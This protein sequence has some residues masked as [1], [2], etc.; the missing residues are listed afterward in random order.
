M[1]HIKTFENFLKE[2]IK[3]GVITC[4]NCGWD[5]EIVPGGEE[6]Y[7]C[8]KCDHDNSP[9][10]EKFGD[11]HPKNKYIE[12]NAKDAAEYA[13]DIVKLINNAYSDKGGNLKIKNA[14]DIKN[15]DITYWVLK[16]IDADP[17]ADVTVGGYFTPAGI[18]M[19]VMGQDG[20]RESKKEAITK[21]I[22][23]MKTR[24]FYAEFDKELA[25]KM[26]LPHIQ[27]EKRVREVLTA[28]QQKFFTWNN[29][30][31]Y[32]RKIAGGLHTKVMVGMPR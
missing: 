31:S 16:D 25:Q 3:D 18:K 22:E 20:S 17:D 30:G 13:E 5:G 6:P 19:T 4:D 8:H 15:G 21:M 2:S 12:L 11:D 1:R 26:G 32:E 29:D 9:M 23:L 14:N 28:D 27:V 24:G 10:N 7:L